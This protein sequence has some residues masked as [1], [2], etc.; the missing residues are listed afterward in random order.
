MLIMGN[1]LVHET[2]K[3]LNAGI[4]DVGAVRAG[5]GVLYDIQS[6]KP[7]LKQLG[8]MI[9]R[10]VEDDVNYIRQ[11]IGVLFQDSFS[12]IEGWFWH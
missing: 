1:P 7:W 8:M 6:I 12:A 3:R 4:A 5:S 10:I 11:R 9:A 2:P